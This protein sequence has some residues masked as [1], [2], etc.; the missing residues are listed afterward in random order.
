MD[1]E[2]ESKRAIFE[3]YA[4]EHRRV[5]IDGFR[6]EELPELVRYTGLR[7]GMDGFVQFTRLAAGS[8]QRIIQEQI[9][10]FQHHKQGFE[11]KVFDFDSPENLCDLLR[12]SGFIAGV[13]ELFLVFDVKIGRLESTA[14]ISIKQI[15]DVAEMAD[16]ARVNEQVWGDASGLGQ[17][18]AEMTNRQNEFSFYCAYS[19][20]QPVATG[21]LVIPTGSVFAY[22]RGGSVIASMRG[23]GIY[24]ALLQTRLTHARQRG[25]EY[26]AVDALPMSRP[27]LERKGFVPI[28]RTIPMIWRS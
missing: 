15:V 8:E 26:L 14:D 7:P 27:I 10:H 17:L 18:A 5:E 19:E 20:G 6:R 1:S 2:S 23:R 16:V 21:G 25:C 4:A 3:R 11:W 9:A 28:C 24:S 13:E 12:A 22:L